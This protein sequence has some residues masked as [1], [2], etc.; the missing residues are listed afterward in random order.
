MILEIGKIEKLYQENI[1]PQIPVP[2]RISHSAIHLLNGFKRR[3]ADIVDSVFI[4]KFFLYLSI[5]AYAACQR[6]SSAG[7]VFCDP[8]KELVGSYFFGTIDFTIS[9]ILASES[10]DDAGST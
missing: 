9:I 3:N 1:N 10:E 7:A 4:I 6:C 8:L 2:T 5:N